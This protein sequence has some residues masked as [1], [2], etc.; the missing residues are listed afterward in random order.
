[1]ILVGERNAKEH[2]RTASSWHQFIL[3]AVAPLGIISII[4]SAIRLS[5]FGFLQ[6]LLGRDAERRIKTMVELT[7]LSVV[8]TVEVVNDG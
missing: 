4:A 5:G 2:M 8:P 7:P 3:F 1:M 6:R